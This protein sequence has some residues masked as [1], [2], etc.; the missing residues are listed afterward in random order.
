MKTIEITDEMYNSLIELSK[1][2]LSQDNR[3]TAMP[4]MFQIQTSEKKQVPDGYG[5]QAWYFDGSLIETSEE[6]QHA[7]FE[8]KEWDEENQDDYDRLEDYEIEEILTAAG[9]QETSY[10]VEHSYENTFFTAKGCDDHIK[11]NHYH[12]EEPICYLN[13]AFRN[14]EME[15]ISKFLCELTGGI[16]HK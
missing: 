2:M 7:V 11:R 5:E 12:Y 9:W 6:I 16:I 13:H 3:A 15:L 14:P 8:W 1:E 4:H 10:V